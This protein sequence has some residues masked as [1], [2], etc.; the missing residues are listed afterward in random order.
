MAD[1]IT[2]K[3]Y[4]RKIFTWGQLNLNLSQTSDERSKYLL[5]L[6]KADNGDF[7]DLISFARS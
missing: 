2:E 6:K 1:L 4:H 7:S 3:I 5:A